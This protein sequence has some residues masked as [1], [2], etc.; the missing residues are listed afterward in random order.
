MSDEP[1]YAT[2]LISSIAMCM[3]GVS[4]NDIKSL[5]VVAGPSS[6]SSSNNALTTVFKRLY[7]QLT[8]TSSSIS[9][10]YIVTVTTG[11]QS[12]ES[13]SGQLKSAVSTGLFT[14]YLHSMTTQTGA[15]GFASASSSS[16]ETSN[17]LDS[18][19][20]NSD[21]SS[22]SGL[23]GG[24]IAGIVIGCVAFVVMV[25]VAVWF[26]AHRKSS[27]AQQQEINLTSATT[28]QNKV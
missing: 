4:G 2:T 25:I 28:M 18:S 23:S 6:V 10:T 27:L 11:T 5:T 8:S 24:A 12:Y 22:G 20:D 9:A 26:F 1:T 21:S 19:D 14:S 17:N 3:T 13:L 7:A 15:T 16:V